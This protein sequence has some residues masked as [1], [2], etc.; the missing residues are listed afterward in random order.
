LETLRQRQLLKALA[1]AGADAVKVGIGP[2]SICTTR[3]IAGVGVP[4]LTAVMDVAEGLMGTG[5]P[6]IA[7]GGIRYTGD[8]AKAIAGGASTVMVG[9]MLA[10]VEESPVRLLSMRE[11]DLNR[12][13]EWVHLRPCNTVVKT[14]IFRMR[15]T[16]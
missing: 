3:I 1:E 7:D 16:I 8:I 9:S 5:V 12:I 14:D 2:G 15:K 13:G 6:L 11:E 4:Q 10:G